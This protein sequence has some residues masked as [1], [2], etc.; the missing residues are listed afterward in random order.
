VP[1]AYLGLSMS[2]LNEFQKVKAVGIRAVDGVACLPRNGL[3]KVTIGVWRDEAN[4]AALSL[5]GLAGISGGGFGLNFVGPVP[6]VDADDFVPVKF[7]GEAACD[8]VDP[9][10]EEGEDVAERFDG[11]GDLEEGIIARNLFGE[12]ALLEP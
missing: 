7:T 8:E 9:A 2:G 10:A 4:A 5:V 11:D 6:D 1:F 12:F 3:A